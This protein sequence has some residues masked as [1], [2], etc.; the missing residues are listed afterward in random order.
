MKN[1]I[2]TISR[3]FGSGGRTVG[4]ETAARLGIPCYDYEIIERVAKDSGF[5]KEYIAEQ[6]EYALSNSWIGNALL[7][8]Y[9]SRGLSNQDYL[10]LSQRKVICELAEKSSCVIIGRC[11]DYILKDK[12]D[13]LTVFIHADIEKRK[14][15]IVKLYGESSEAPE[16]RLKDKD[17][18]RGAYYR[19]YTDMEWGEARNYHVSLDSGVLGIEKCVDIITSLY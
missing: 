5:A 8:T 13:L 10:W 19:Y 16:K 12:A 14:E 1:R 2:I 4:K 15:R 18:R 7:S 9:P 17:K 3:E 6:G 11:A